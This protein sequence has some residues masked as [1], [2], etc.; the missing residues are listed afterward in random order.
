MIPWYVLYVKVV[1]LDTTVCMWSSCGLKQL[2][3]L[4]GQYLRYLTFKKHLLTFKGSLQKRANT[5]L[6]RKGSQNAAGT[7]PLP[8][9][10]TKALSDRHVQPYH[11][12]SPMH[13]RVAQTQGLYP[14]L[15]GT[16]TFNSKGGKPTLSTWFPVHLPT[17]IHS[18]IHPIVARHLGEPGI[19]PPTTWELRGLVLVR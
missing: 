2:P 17:M 9:P 4:C 5:I 7:Q 11:K 15:M 12:K 3:Y 10:A 19:F 14:D 18:T 6:T 1:N 16:P 8:F 13:E